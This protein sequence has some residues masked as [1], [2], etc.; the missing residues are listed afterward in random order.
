MRCL[1]VLILALLAACGREAV[2]AAVPTAEEQRLLTLLTMDPSVIVREY[3][4]DLQG[5]L[6]VT[7]HQ[8]DVCVRYILAAAPGAALSIHRLNEEPR[9]TVANDG[10]KGTGPEPRGLR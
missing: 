3:E 2:P 7:T 4:R 8:G 6:V 5:R 1:L 10:T 9:L